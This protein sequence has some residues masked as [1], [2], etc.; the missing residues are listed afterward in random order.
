M[1]WRR[2]QEERPNSSTSG[3]QAGGGPVATRECSVVDLVIVLVWEVKSANELHD[4]QLG[5]KSDLHLRASEG[6]RA[7]GLPSFPNTMPLRSFLGGAPGS[8][9]V[10]AVP[11]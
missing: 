1:E 9:T 4:R 10:E 3:G 6:Y 5:K 8:A 11:S 7:H 2:V